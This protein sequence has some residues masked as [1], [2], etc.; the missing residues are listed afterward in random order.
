MAQVAVR[1]TD[2]ELAGLDELVR[3]GRFESRTAAIRQALADQRRTESDCALAEAY[4]RAYAHTP[5]TEDERDL[6][7]VG[8]AHLADLYRT[9]PSDAR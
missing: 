1:L 2:D 3:E 5:I 4:R 7:D 8:A 9:E 6:A